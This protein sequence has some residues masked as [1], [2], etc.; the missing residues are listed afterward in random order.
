MCHSFGEKC[1]ENP[2]LEQG[3]GVTC[4]Q[5]C[6]SDQM[7]ITPVTPQ[8]ILLPIRQLPLIFGTVETQDLRALNHACFPMNRPIVS[9]LL[10]VLLAITSPA[11][12]DWPEF[13]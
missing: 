11:I 6:T 2:S 7:M 1:R 9:V 3:G 12:A 8:K 5:I 4:G 13:R 10:L